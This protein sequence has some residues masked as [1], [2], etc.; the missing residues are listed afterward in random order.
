MPK[1]VTY[2]EMTGRAELRP[3]PAVP[4]LGLRRVDSSSPLV[5]ST[6]ARIGAPHGWRSTARTGEEWT[7]AIAARPL[8]QYWLLTHGTDVAGAAFLEP[9]PG[10][11]VEITTFGLLPERVGQGLGGYALTLALRRAWATEPLAA[12]A[13]RRVW[14]HTSSDDH[15]HALAN[16]HRRGLRTYRIE[17]EEDRAAP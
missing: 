5:R 2:L 15:P 8:R 12:D 11:E 1:T 14:L 16:Y 9:Q 6:P 3:A 4:A 13:V 17:V 10:G 7:E